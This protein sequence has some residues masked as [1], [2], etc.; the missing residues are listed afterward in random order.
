[1]QIS[2]FIGKPVLSPS[3]AAYGYITDV[4]LARDYRKVSCLVCVD[5]EEEEFYLPMRTV[6]Q[7]G[8][9]IICGKARL[10][11]P[12]GI[13]SPI[14]RPAYSHT[15]E[16]L[17]TVS[18]VTIGEGPEAVLTVSGKI[19]TTAL[20][21]CVSIAETV[22]VYP[23]AIAKSAA[24]KRT[25]GTRK[26]AIKSKSERTP[27]PVHAPEQ[28][29]E[30]PPK[31]D[32]PAPAPRPEIP[33]KEDAPTPEPVQLIGRGNL[34]GRHVRRSVY[35]RSGALIAMQGEKITPAILQ[36]ARR[37]GKLLELTVNTLTTHF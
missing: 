37:A 26:T 6:L 16:A 28:Q 33:P 8:D 9:A 7:M 30:L 13:P 32:T 11:S 24:A 29:P 10:S 3:G 35:D 12:T 27:A 36:S 1:M 4:R 19:P 31:E 25:G 23:N 18:D 21:P 5:S 20:I 22:I 15:G 17:G 34:L 14:G 2:S